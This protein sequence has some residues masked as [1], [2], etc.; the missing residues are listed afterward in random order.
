ML[1]QGIV[2]CVLLFHKCVLI[3]SVYM[4][5]FV[6]IYCVYLINSRLWYEGT[7]KYLGESVTGLKSGL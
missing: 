5:I 1:P 3:W 6:C 7:L 2:V 4:S